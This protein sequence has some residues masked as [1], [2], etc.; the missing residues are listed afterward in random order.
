[1][2]KFYFLMS[3]T[4]FLALSPTICNAQETK[5]AA[6]R[7]FTGKEVETKPVE[8]YTAPMIVNLDISDQKITF[9]KT[10]NDVWNPPIVSQSSRTAASSEAA[11]TVQKSE[12][13]FREAIEILKA[14][15]LY[16]ASMQHGV[17]VIAVPTY[18]ITSENGRDYTITVT[19]YPA[20]YRNFRE[21]T[22]ADRELIDGYKYHQSA[23]P[24]YIA[25]P[26]DKTNRK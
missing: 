5:G 13:S 20:R 12:K 7:E 9:T 22:P 3:I 1:M 23:V 18:S 11:K 10:Y 25:V 15:A 6:F 17:D 21:L 4:A 16:D 8:F 24:T 14:N 2:R 26:E 19:G